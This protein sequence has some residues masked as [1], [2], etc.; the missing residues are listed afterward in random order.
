MKEKLES[1]VELIV[2]WILSHG[3]KIIVIALIVYVVNLILAR[4]VRRTVKIAVV[5]EEGMSEEAELKRENTLIRI[6]NGAIRIILITIG[7]M[8]ILPEFGIEIGPI[9]AGAGVVGLA[10][11]FGAQYLI[12]D[13]ITGLFIILENQ[14]RIG[15]VINLGSEGGVVED[16][17]LRMTTLRDLNGTVHHIPHGEV[18]RVSNLTKSYSRVNIN[19]GISYNANIEKVIDVIN[20]TGEKLAEDPQFKDLII[21]PPK[22]LRV[23]EFADSSVVVKI[24]G[25]TKASKQWDVAGEFRKRIKAE[26]DREG[27]EIPFP[28]RVVHQI[29]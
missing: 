9:L 14:Y 16:I 12:R 19:I 22:F 28:Q 10:V 6:F 26:F 5:R 3:I 7:L 1:W 17:S 21:S 29:K 2:P 23:D 25:D 11:G 4:I 8:M 15:D 13:I 24:L 20:R 27:I 18:T